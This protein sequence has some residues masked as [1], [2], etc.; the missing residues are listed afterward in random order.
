MDWYKPKVMCTFCINV[1]CQN[2]PVTKVYPFYEID[3]MRYGTYSNVFCFH[4]SYIIIEVEV[5]VNVTY[6]IC[7]I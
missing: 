2:L 4:M 5:E 3:Q 7:F 1:G 6:A